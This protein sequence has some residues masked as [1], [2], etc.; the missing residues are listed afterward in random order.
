MGA[1]TLIELL[2]VIAIIAILAA[3][4]FPTLGKAKA[5]AQA[6]GCINNKRQLLTAWVMYSQD[7][8]DRLALN[9]PAGVPGGWVDGEMCWSGVHLPDNIDALKLT[10]ALLGLYT[11]KQIRLYHCPADHSY[12]Q[13]QKV[14]RL[15]SVS[16]NAFVGDPGPTRPAP[17]YVYHGW[18]QFIKLSDFR[19]PTGIFVFLDEHPD[20][21]NDGWFV[22]CT[23][24]K[25]PETAEWSDVPASYHDR[26]C[27]FAFA[28]G[29][30]EIHKW[31]S[32]STI[33]PNVMGGIGTPTLPVPPSPASEQQ[34]IIWVRD[35]STC[36]IH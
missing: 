26:A 24:K 32:A 11:A 27:S 21:I 30:A 8:N 31:K 10:R 36:E 14:E 7:H 17:D 2:V 29:H 16:M 1:F 33:K 6:F 28:D 13:G 35:R 20:S 22:Y 12:G 23:G 5:R 34:D 25:P 4:L 15:R 18:Q 9:Y 19:D 3:L